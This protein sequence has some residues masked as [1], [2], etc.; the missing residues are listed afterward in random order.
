MSWNFHI[1]ETTKSNKACFTI[2]S[3]RLTCCM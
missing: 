1:E 3:A 2:R